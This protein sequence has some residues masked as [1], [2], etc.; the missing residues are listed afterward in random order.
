MYNCEISTIGS[1]IQL[2]QTNYQNKGYFKIDQPL[3]R[4]FV[5]YAQCLSSPP[6]FLCS[7]IITHFLNSMIFTNQEKGLEFELIVKP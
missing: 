1:G 5:Y 3:A 2:R 7:L 4:H 6:P